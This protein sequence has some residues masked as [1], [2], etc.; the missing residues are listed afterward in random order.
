MPVYPLLLILSFLPALCDLQ[1]VSFPKQGWN[2]EIESLA[3]ILARLFT[4]S[5]NERARPEL[6][7]PMPLHKKRLRRRGFNQSL[8]LARLISKETGI[9]VNA[10]ACQRTRHTQPQSTLPAKEKKNNVKNAFAVNQLI[11]TRHVTIVDD[12]M[13]SGH[14]ANEL[15]RVLKLAGVEQVDIWVMARAATKSA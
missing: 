15:A 10:H 7:I 11:E 3:K 12:V 6:L 2:P 13:T 5:L 9:P 14:T 4:D 8:E 1:E